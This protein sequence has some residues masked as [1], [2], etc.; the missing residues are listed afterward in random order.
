VTFMSDGVSIGNHALSG[1]VAVLT[2]KALAAGAHNITATYVGSPSY[3]TSTGALT[4]TV[5]SGL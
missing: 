2:T 4:Q 5:G 1:G 3:A